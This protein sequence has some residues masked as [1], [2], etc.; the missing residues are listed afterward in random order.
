MNVPT[1][2]RILPV[3]KG[4]RR[5]LLHLFAVLLTLTVAIPRASTAHAATICTLTATGPSCPNYPPPDLLNLNQTLYAATPAQA[6]SLQNL[7]D[8]AVSDIITVHNLADA[9]ADAVKSWARAD[10]EAELYKLLLQAIA[11]SPRTADQQNAVDWLTAVMQRQAVTAAEDAGLQYVK[12]AGLDQSKYQSL[13]NNNASESDLQSFL[14][15]SPDNYDNPNPSLATGGWC[16]YRSPAPYASEYTGYNDVTCTNQCPAFCFPPTPSYDQFTKWGEADASY[17]LLS[18]GDYQS[19]AQSMAL[20]LGL[21]VSLGV[22]YT[23]GAVLGY[24]AAA[25]A[26][27]ASAWVGVG[28]E[29]AVTALDIAVGSI[30]AV[31]AFATIAVVIA[32]LVTAIIVGINVTDAAKLPGKLATL[33]SGAETTAPDPASLESTTD[34]ATTI[35]NLFV[36]ATLPAP[37]NRTCDNSGIDWEFIPIVADGVTR[38][39]PNAPCLNLTDIPPA[40][41]TDPQFLVQA[42]GAT[43]QMTS[44]TITWKDAASGTTITAR[45]SENWFIEQANGA[46]VQTLRM[47]YTDWNGAEQTAWLLGDPTHGY[48]FLALSS[49][50]VDPST[51]VADGTCSFSPSIDYVGSDGQDYSAT[52][53]GYM[54]PTG[55]PSYS[56][57]VEASP[58]TFKANDFAPAAAT[59]PI[60]YTWQFQQ[61]GCGIPC[62]SFDTTTFTSGPEYT[63]PVSGVTA[64][65]TWQT[66]GSYLVSLTATD[67]NGVQANDTFT[68]AVGDVPPTL[69]LYPACSSSPYVLQ[70]LCNPQTGD[71]GTSMPFAGTVAHTGSLDNEIVTVNWGDGSSEDTTNAGP[72]SL[73]LAGNS[74]TLTLSSDGTYYTLF[75]AHTYTKPGTYTATVWATIGA[76]VRTARRSRRR[77]SARRPLASRPSPCIRMAMPRSPSRRPAAA[78]ARL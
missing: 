41:P 31:G 75:D 62:Q 2:H 10:A 45:L 32:A 53:R 34:G 37:V 35:Y 39:I 74:L 22:I 52:V 28:V 70:L 49:R 43:T 46:T 21:G 78:R 64:T 33:I 59:A 58:V 54:P 63:H 36:G 23:T 76:V 38:L 6:A 18:T 60:T 44:P 42:K 51:C 66:S 68:V 67:A 72:N 57:A 50:T 13:L 17:P 4:R 15:T 3:S 77:S 11:A 26:S 29:E 8:K 19:T 61:A 55:S 14:S 56:T 71:V 9:D 5:A 40:G 12:W 30:S 47:T 20:G 25:A 7:E 48:G 27:T 1:V 69:R 73:S 24:F 16:V 65:Y